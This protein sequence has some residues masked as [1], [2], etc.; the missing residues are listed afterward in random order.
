MSGPS[1]Y[2]PQ[3]GFERWLDVFKK[4]AIAAG[5]KD[6]VMLSGLK[7]GNLDLIWKTLE[8]R[9]TAMDK[10]VQFQQTEKDRQER[11]RQSQQRLDMTL[12]IRRRPAYPSSP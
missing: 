5:V 8:Q 9:Q 1:T 3:S 7:T 4:D 10:L 12:T 11:L 6:E 2:N